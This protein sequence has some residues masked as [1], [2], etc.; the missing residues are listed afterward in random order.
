MAVTLEPE[1]ASVPA[2]PSLPGI[3]LGFLRLGATAFAGAGNILY[4]EHLAVSQRRWLDRETYRSGVALSQTL[5]GAIAM[6]AAAY[7]G[8][9]LRGLSGAL[10]AYLGFGI[11]AF[12]LMLGLSALYQRTHSLPALLSLFAGLRVLVVALIANAA[13]SFGRSSV[14]S[15]RDGLIALLAAAI[16]GLATAS[17]ALVIVFAALAGSLVL[18]DSPSPS[19]SAAS[20]PGG[21]E[22]WRWACQLLAAGGLALL[23]LYLFDRVLFGLA[24]TM[25]RIDLLAF[26][27]GFTSVPLMQHDFVDVHRWMDAR[28]FLDGIVLGQATPG[29]IVITATFAG[30]MLRGTGGAVVGTA[31]VFFPS[32]VLLVLAAPHFERLQTAPAFRGAVRG[33]LLSLVGLLAVVTLRFGL[34]TPWSPTAALLGAAAFLALLRKVDVL[35]VVLAGGALSLVLMH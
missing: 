19:V 3:F 2:A 15:R 4:I 5:P 6:H 25:I 12:L 23:L 8:L 16:F 22:S 31:A 27:G 26:G 7:V 29:P 33:I 11:P 9:R 32:L 28:T 10:A 13:V 21:R 20:L 17:P 1:A 18:R 24:L 14:K 34:A 35:W 30:Y